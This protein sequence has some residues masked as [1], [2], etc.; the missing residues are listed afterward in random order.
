MKDSISLE[1]KEKRLQRLNEVVN[2]YAREN[3]EKLL[4]KE[5]FVL[6]EGKSDKNKDMF[7]GY[8]DTN[9]LVNFSSQKDVI[10][11]IVEV[12][13]TDA[14]TWSLDGEYID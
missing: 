9:K 5:V 10:G 2:K 6:A 13:I 12:K 14:K 7:M 4:G 11:K 8:T 3:N 1:E